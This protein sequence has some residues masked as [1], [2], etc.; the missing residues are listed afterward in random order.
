MIEKWSVFV[1]TWRFEMKKK[2]K[3]G[4]YIEWN[5]DKRLVCHNKHGRGAAAEQ[6]EIKCSKKKSKTTSIILLFSISP[7]RH[8]HTQAQ[9]QV[10]TIQPGRCSSRPLV[11]FTNYSW[12]S[13]K[14]G[15]GFDCTN[16][17]LRTVGF[18]WLIQFYSFFFFVSVV[19][20]A[21]AVAVAVIVIRC[22]IL[23]RELMTI[24][25]CDLN[26]VCSIRVLYEREC[27]THI[28][29]RCY[30]L[31]ALYSF[32]SFV[33]VAYIAQFHRVLSIFVRSFSSARRFHCR[34]GKFYIENQNDCSSFFIRSWSPA[35]RVLI[36]LV[37]SLLFHSDFHFTVFAT[38][39]FCI[40]I[41]R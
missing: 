32:P 40:G 11:S 14:Y 20:D 30:V 27:S 34:F 10:H 31:H 2:K 3:N 24:K 28:M 9:A 38:V 13:R 23:N 17:V 5:Y 12:M 25:W 18:T 26:R 36:I 35:K 6:I 15:N 21:D 33:F 39:R 4:N 19:A 8:I 16:E 41:N 29:Q 22:K 37:N 7:H 1:P